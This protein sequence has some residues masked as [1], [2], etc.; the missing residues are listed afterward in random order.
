[1]PFTGLQIRFSSLDLTHAFSNV[2]KLKVDR[3]SEMCKSKI[4]HREGTSKDPRKE[5][6]EVTQLL[7]LGGEGT[8]TAS[9]VTVEAQKTTNS[10]PGWLPDVDQVDDEMAGNLDH[11]HSPTQQVHPDSDNTTFQEAMT[12]EDA[13]S[14]REFQESD[15]ESEQADVVDIED[16]Y[17]YET[18]TDEEDQ[19]DDDDIV[20]FSDESPS[21]DY[22]PLNSLECMAP[23]SLPT[24]TPN[25]KSY[26]SLYSEESGYCDN[27]SSDS[28][29][30][31]SDDEGSDTDEIPPDAS[32][33]E[34]I[35]K[36]FE[37][38]AL[39]RSPQ[40]TCKKQPHVKP[41]PVAKTVKAA[42]SRDTKCIVQAPL[43]TCPVS[44]TSSRACKRVSFKPEPELAV[45]HYMVTWSHAYRSCRKGPW[46]QYA[47]DRQHFRRRI[48]S[49]ACILRPCLE[50][51]L[52]CCPDIS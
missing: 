5:V 32:S 37:I 25:D 8:P 36:A 51:K 23:P 10:D 34:E 1:M 16:E 39:S 21:P 44:P 12:T 43:P 7:A 4:T 22:T 9:G 48:E 3:E 46:E 26:C 17:G 24:L 49:M 27:G 50:K 38:Q 2:Q 45:V 19:D 18:D 41:G 52:N 47:R 11:I 20:E 6:Q 31:W 30:S 33:C 35:W 29:G 28:P 42:K 15:N 14:D 40:L 13:E